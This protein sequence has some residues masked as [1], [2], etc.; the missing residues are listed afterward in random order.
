MN[1]ALLSIGDE[2]ALG[3]TVDTNSAWLAR[4][5]ATVGVDA[6][7]H[8]TVD[9][10]RGAIEEALRYLST[11]ADLLLVSGG[12]GPTED[13]L[14]RDA[15][16]AVLD[17]PLDADDRWVEQLKTFFEQ[18]GRAMP[19]RNKVQALVPRGAELIWNHHGTAP[20]LRAKLNNAEVVVM[21]GVPKEMQ[22]MFERDVLPRVAE[23]AGGR[24]IV[25]RTLHT[26]GVG[27]SDVAVR[28]G[29]DLM[30]RGRNPS[31][32]TT[33]AN[34]VVSLRVNSR[35]DTRKQAGEELEATVALC[36]E[37]LGDLIYGSDDDELQHVVSTMLRERNLTVATAES[38]TGG[39]I[40]KMLTD[41]PGSSLSYM[42]GVVTY[43]NK[44][45]MERLAVPTEVL[46]LYGAVS[47][48]VVTH[49][50]RAARRLF[51]THLALAVS[52]VAGPDGGSPTKPVGT[53]CLAL[54]WGEPRAKLA[55]EGEAVA[56]TFNFAGPRA[57]VRDRS[58]K[59]TLTMLRFHLLGE[60]LPF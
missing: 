23:R 15:L 4:Q 44:S 22:L 9:D 14:T 6:K 27:E 11:K 28:V 16:A 47:E 1:A 13:D 24:A 31:V 50:A 34:G 8:L 48:P 21:P 43:S 39:L 17:A 2:L 3:Q 33:V 52:G 7:L 20:G 40:G 42:G 49:M 60:P 35:F 37:R 19:E 5:L 30:M 18:R 55:V 57:W 36:K 46:N 54:A 59:M 10:D 25:S 12:L 41:A 51:G 26:F 53:V 29:G 45:K 58:A 32:G 38:C 56:R